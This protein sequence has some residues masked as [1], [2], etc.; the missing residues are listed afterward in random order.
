MK[1]ARLLLKAFQKAPQIR[2]FRAPPSSVPST[3][4]T[5][6]LR[7]LNDTESFSPFSKRWTAA[8]LHHGVPQV[9]SASHFHTST[10][11][12]SAVSSDIPD[13]SG[14]RDNTETSA[15]ES[16]ATAASEDTS[17][18]VHRVDT[19]S[20]E[21]GSD[22]AELLAERDAQLEER[23]KAI[24]ELQEKVLRSYAEVENILARSQREAESTRKF[25]LQGFAKGLLDVAD[26]LGRATG[27]VPQSFR[28]S[29][30]TSEGS[31]EA[32]K[33][34]RSLLQGVEMTEKQLQQVF[35]MNGLEKFESDGQEFDPNFHSAMFEMEDES[36]TPGTVAVVTKVGYKLHD[37]VIRPAEV[38]V[39]KAKE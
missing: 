15:T 4:K 10:T 29:D 17:E 34:L 8:T 28:Q 25:A 9:S 11:L 7:R 16:S 24:K 33:H 13:V 2:S 3:G 19:P 18:P 26:N 1:H 37:R 27:A 12:S 38:G 14:K 22:L 31:S 21:K 39:V 6:L 23:D 30:A 5:V 32:A 35:R 36:K 20:D